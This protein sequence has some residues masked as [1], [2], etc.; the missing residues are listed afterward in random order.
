MIT[1]LN[2]LLLTGGRFLCTPAWNKPADGIDQCYKIYRV[3]TGSAA[4]TTVAGRQ[5]P[6][7]GRTYLIDGH[8]LRSQKCHRRMD[9]FWVHFS[10]ESLVL[11]RVL[12]SLPPVVDIP[13]ASEDPMEAWA[14]LMQL[15]ERP[16]TD[17]SRPLDPPPL[18][19]FCRVQ[20]LLL[21]LLGRA[22][23]R[24]RKLVEQDAW[25]GIQPFRRVIEMM[26]TRFR[27]NLPLLELASAAGM[28]PAYFHRRF[29]S[30]FGLC[31]HE[32]MEKRRMNLARNLLADPGLR[33]KEV[34]AAA[35]YDNPFYFSRVF[36]LRFGISPSGLRARAADRR[37]M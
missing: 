36:R 32:Y 11:D 22:L 12:S 13:N 35:G 30:A 15:F 19:T 26:D 18:A 24:H 31:P 6:R 29:R 14:D 28:A 10:P 34:A 25:S 17:A 9:V 3:V 4:L 7:A 20:G 27:E 37:V 21:H 5:P 2:F 23:H 33:I 1:N 8:R 16:R